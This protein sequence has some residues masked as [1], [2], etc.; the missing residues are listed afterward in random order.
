MYSL[1]YSTQFKRDFKK[2]AKMSIS[3]IIEVGSVIS[4]L[5]LREKA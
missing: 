5:Q 4:K 2:I 1:E 3:D